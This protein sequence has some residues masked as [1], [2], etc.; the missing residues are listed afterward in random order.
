MLEPLSS[1]VD[2]GGSVSVT[3]RVR[4]TGDI[5]EEYHVDVVG[6]PALW[7]VIEPSTVRLYPGTTANVRL[8]FTPPRNSDSTAGPHPFGVRVTPVETPDA[9]M[10]PEGN[11]TV[12]PFVDVRAE[13]LPVTIR[14]WRRAKPRLVVDNY[15]N[16]TATAAVVADG[17][18]NRLDFDI[19]NP[20]I[21]IPPGRANFSLLRLRPDRT[22]WLGQ[23]IN[24]PYTTTLQLSGAEP[25]AATGTFVQTALLPRWIARLFAVLAA[26]LAAFAGLWFAIHPTVSTA[27]TAENTPAAASA[28][29]SAP[30]TTAAP[31]PS[32]TPSASASASS[33]PATTPA[34]QG[35]AA[36]N[37]SA[38]SSPPITLPPAVAY[39]KLNDASG[40]TAYDDA[41]GDNN[42]GTLSNV[43]W[44][45]NNCAEFGGN[46]GNSSVTS[47]HTALDTSP[48]GSF[49]V[50]VG[51]DLYSGSAGKYETMVSQDG[52]NASGFYLQVLP[53]GYWAFSRPGTQCPSTSPAVDDQW[54]TVT[55][56]YDSSDTSLS[57]YVSGKLQNTC[58]LT[59]GY[60]AQATSGDVAIGRAFSNGGD[61]DWCSAFLDDVVLFNS[62]LSPQQMP[63]MLKTYY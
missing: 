22:L 62:A 26:L 7:C 5:V 29:I 51:V 49:T 18:G 24:H 23:K 28:T 48:S 20:A 31:S 32:V 10:V 13:L 30:A 6:D 2:A 21:Q 33:A 52:S 56:V 39:W 43:G 12:T 63:L 50:S 8:T 61:A 38:S 44:C 59:N 41:E 46:A 42:P 4:N 1:T 14:G 25:V 19:R 3:L 55:G 16:T 57:I 34:T 60:P 11:V 9:V 58:N 53:D 17:Q 27:T 40:N 37:T 45:S 35:A 54:T 47:A 15:G 36:P